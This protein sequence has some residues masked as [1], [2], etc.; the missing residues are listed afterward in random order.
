MKAG[1]QGPRACEY[2]ANGGR[3]RKQ[4]RIVTQ[5][6]QRTP[7]GEKNNCAFVESLQS[8]KQVYA[9]RTGTMLL[10]LIEFSNFF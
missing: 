1:L 10:D 2:H 3:P 6:V 5:R 4:K 9:G 8:S 7:W